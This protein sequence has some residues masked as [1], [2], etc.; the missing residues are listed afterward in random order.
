MN[1][2]K[3]TMK[4]RK[5]TGSG[6]LPAAL[7]VLLSGSAT[8]AQTPLGSGWTYQGKLNVGGSPLN[9]TAD[10]EFTLWDADVNGSMIGEVVETN[11][12]D[13]VD[14]LFTVELDFGAE[15]FNGNNRWLEIDVRSPAG[16]G[17]F[18]TLDPRQPL[19]PAPYALQTRGI[20]VDE[21][22]NV[23]IGETSPSAALDVVGATELNGNVAII[24]GN[25]AVDIDTLFVDGT[26]G[27]VGI[28]TAAPLAELGV[29]G[30]IRFGPVQEFHPVAD[31]AR[32]VIVR[33]KINQDG[34]TVSA[35]TTSGVTSSRLGNGHY[36]V[37]FPAGA[38]SEVPIVTV[39]V[40]YNS[41]TRVAMVE[42]VGTDDFTI[43]I[44]NEFGVRKDE[45]F[46]FIAIGER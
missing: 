38:F 40:F 21:L 35:R 9:D 39:T 10:F 46:N 17:E 41:N 32:T 15:A 26:A 2:L 30:D 12:I 28:G 22:S 34:S 42:S 5:I 36:S 19:T 33:G 25:L 44:R 20:F 14:G 13:V 18:T 8:L 23:G 31:T 43:F 11:D 37:T 1:D 7:A 27:Q 6:W 29:E 16:G 4:T 45:D 24:N 3:C